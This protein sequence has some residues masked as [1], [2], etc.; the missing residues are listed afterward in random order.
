MLKKYIRE[1]TISRLT[2]SLQAVVLDVNGVERCCVGQHHVI[3]EKPDS[4][5]TSYPFLMVSHLGN[6]DLLEV[7]LL[8]DFII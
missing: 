4:I 7:M 1:F 3:V 8:G 2:F 5:F 6:Q